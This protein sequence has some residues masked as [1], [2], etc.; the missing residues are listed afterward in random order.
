[1][2]RGNGMLDEIK[3]RIQREFSKYR[4]RVT[5]SRLCVLTGAVCF[6]LF[7][8]FGEASVWNH[9]RHIRRIRQLERTY[10][11]ARLRYQADSVKLKHITD[12]AEDLEHIARVDYGMKA[13]EE[14]VFLIVDSTE[15]KLEEE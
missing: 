10:K 6:M 11:N 9:F 8:V 4:S 7:F 2:Q 14:L 12:N 3:G 15:Y 1:M 5:I 13:P